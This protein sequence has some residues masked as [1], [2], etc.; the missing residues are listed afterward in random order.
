MAKFEV[1]EIFRLPARQE[2]VIAGR[3][4]EGKV[5]AGMEVRFDLQSG[6][7]CSAS[8]KSVEFIDRVAAQESLAGL[9]LSELDEKEALVYS[10]LCP[11]GTVMRSRQMANKRIESV[12]F[13]RPAHSRRWV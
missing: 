5:A 12:P 3:V 8:V 2:I 11:F 13:G 10:D 7:S 1:H 4:V 9:V 6:L